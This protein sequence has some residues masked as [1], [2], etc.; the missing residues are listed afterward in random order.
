M[1]INTTWTQ[2]DWNKALEKVWKLSRNFE[3]ILNFGLE[4]GFIT[5]LDII[6]ASDIYKDPNKEYDDEEV[7]EMISSRGL[8]ET[9]EIIQNEYSLD[10]ILETLPQDDLLD[11]IP[12][13]N[14]IDYL[15]GSYEL[16]RYEDDIKAQYHSEV[17]DE[18]L[19]EI[20][21]NNENH[22]ANISNW[23]ADELHYLICDIVGCGHY[24]N[25]VYNKLK[26]RL[27]KNNYGVKYE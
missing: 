26:E 16:D 1:K 10:E 22:I 13:D 8:Q 24:D 2:A 23:N 11:S 6:H 14:M 21:T 18:V 3:E 12:N 9:M 27:N 5:N 19:E 4:R 25:A 20:K 7:K 17:L 15:E